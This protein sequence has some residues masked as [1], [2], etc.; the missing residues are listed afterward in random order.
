VR[1]HGRYRVKGSMGYRGHQP[2]EEFVATL[3]VN[4]ERRAVDRGSIVLLDRVTPAIRPGSYRLPRG[5]LDK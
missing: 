4:A 5:W 1:V 3:D 2:G